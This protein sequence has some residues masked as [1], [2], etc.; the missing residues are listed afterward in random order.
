MN[1][2][3]DTTEEWRPVIGYEGRYSVSNLGRVRSERDGR[4][5][6]RGRILKERPHEG[7]V[8]YVLYRDGKPRSLFGHALVAAAFLG[9]C[10]PGKEVNH[11]DE[12]KSNNRPSNL[13]YLTRLENV[14]HSAARH[15]AAQKRGEQHHRTTIDEETVRAMRREGTTRHWMAVTG[16]TQSTIDRIKRRASWAHV[17]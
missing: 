14:R 4:G 16:M 7:Y 5:T 13:E 6:V 9:P 12:D 1:C 11:V 10:P 2:G 15:R 3:Y 17:E 8:R